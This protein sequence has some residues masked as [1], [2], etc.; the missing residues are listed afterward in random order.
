MTTPAGGASSGLGVGK[1]SRVEQTP[2]APGA[3]S[4]RGTL[5]R[6][7]L[8]SGDHRPVMAKAEHEVRNADEANTL[9]RLTGSAGRALAPELAA[10]L[11][12]VLGHDVSHVVIHTDSVAATAA[13]QLGAR[14]FTIGNEIYFA[15]GA[16]A[17][18]TRDGERL[19]IHELTH[20]AQHDRGALSAV[21]DGQSRVSSP[22]DAHEHE[23]RAMES[24]SGEAPTAP[25]TARGTAGSRAPVLRDVHGIA[26]EG[27]DCFMNAVLQLLA[28]TYSTLFEPDIN[29]V[30]PERRPLQVELQRF[31]AGIRGGEP[32]A[33]KSGDTKQL[34]A[35]LRAHKII[36]SDYAQE[37]AAETLRLLLD[38]V[39]SLEGRALTVQGKPR[40]AR[41]GDTLGNGRLG[42]TR[43]ELLTENPALAVLDVFTFERRSELSFQPQDARPRT[44]GDA[45]HDVSTYDA[46]GTSTRIEEDLSMVEIEMSAYDSFEQFM[47]QRYGVGIDDALR[48]G[49]EHHAVDHQGGGIS[50]SKLHRTFAFARL[51]Q[52]MTFVVQRFFGDIKLDDEFQMPREMVLKE[53]TQPEQYCR[54]DLRAM[55][56]HDSAEA[57]AGH[58]IAEVDDDQ[59]H[60]GWMTVDDRAV[61][62][63]ETAKGE[64]LNAP[65]R[66]A[67]GYLYSY[68]LVERSPDPP[69][70]A[71][72][73]VQNT[74]P[75]PRKR[76]PL[77]ERPSGALPPRAQ[78][79]GAT[80]GET[81]TSDKRGLPN[82]ARGGHSKSDCFINAIVQLAAG[83]YRAKFDPER[84][85]LGED[86]ARAQ[87]LV[88]ALIC[89]IDKTDPKAPVSSDVAA[90]RDELVRRDIIKTT[91]RSED[92]SE[93]LL[94][95]LE[96]VRDQSPGELATR[97]SRTL[98]LSG[99][100]AIDVDEDGSRGFQR[101]TGGKASE[102][103]VRGNGYL[104][105]DIRQYSNIHQ[106]LYRAYGSG[107]ERTA[108]AETNRPRV[109]NDGGHVSIQGST[110]HT[111][112]VTLP[113][114]LTLQLQRLPAETALAT[115]KAAAPDLRPFYMPPTL[116]LV[117]HPE[118]GEKQYVSYQLRGVVTW[119]SAHYTAR[120]AHGEQWYDFNDE[121]VHAAPGTGDVLTGGYLYTYVAG[122]RSARP[123]SG[124]VA[125]QESAPRTGSVALSD[126]LVADYDGNA[127]MHTPTQRN[128]RAVLGTIGGHY[129]VLVDASKGVAVATTASLLDQI[130]MLSASDVTAESE[131][132]R[133]IVASCRDLV[134]A[135]GASSLTE[136]VRGKLPAPARSAPRY[137][138]RGAQG[139]ASFTR[140][141]DGTQVDLSTRKLPELRAALA[142]RKL[143]DSPE[144]QA[145]LQFRARKEFYEQVHLVYDLD[146]TLITYNDGTYTPPT[147]PGEVVGELALGFET[148][149]PKPSRAPTDA[150]TEPTEPTAEP[151]A[152]RYPFEIDALVP[153]DTS[154]GD[155]QASYRRHGDDRA[156]RQHY[157]PKT[158]RER[159]ETGETLD[160]TGQRIGASAT[161]QAPST[162]AR[163]APSNQ[164]GRGVN[165]RAMSVRPGTI[166]ALQ[167]LDGY[168]VHQSVWT[169]NSEHHMH[170]VLEL[171]EDLGFAEHKFD[172]TMSAKDTKTHGRKPLS[173]FERPPGQTTL[174][175]DDQPNRGNTVLGELGGQG[176]LKPLGPD[177]SGELG[178][179][180]WG[181]AGK[182]FADAGKAS[183]LRGLL[184]DRLMVRLALGQVMPA[185]EAD[186]PLA[187]EFLDAMKQIVSPTAPIADST[188]PGALDTFLDQPEAQ[189]QLRASFERF[190]PPPAHRG[191]D[192]SLFALTPSLGASLIFPDKLPSQTDQRA[193]DYDEEAAKLRA[194]T[195]YKGANVVSRGLIETEVLDKRRYVRVYQ[196]EAN[197][198]ARKDVNTTIFKDVH[199][200]EGEIELVKGKGA[201]CFSVGTPLRS[202]KWLE[203]YQEEHFGKG[204]NPVIRSFLIPLDVYIDM[205]SRANVQEQSSHPRYDGKDVSTN[206]DIAG[207]TDQYE[208]RE[209]DLELLRTHAVSGSLVSW[210]LDNT[211]LEADVSGDVRPLR[212]LYARLGLTPFSGLF[213][214]FKVVGDAEHT[215]D[216]FTEMGGHRTSGM[217]ERAAA[218]GELHATH[219]EVTTGADPTAFLETNYDGSAKRELPARITDLSTFLRMHFFNPPEGKRFALAMRIENEI[220]KPIERQMALDKQADDWEK[221]K[222][223]A[224]KKGEPEP[225][226]PKLP[227]LR[228]PHSKLFATLVKPTQEPMISIRGELDA[229][230]VEYEDYLRAQKPPVAVPATWTDPLAFYNEVLAPVT[231]EAARY[232]TRMARITEERLAHEAE[233]R[234]RQ[235]PVPAWTD[236]EF[237][238]AVLVPGAATQ[239]AVTQAIGENVDEARADLT[240]QHP[241][242]GR[243]FETLWE[244]HTS[245]TPRLDP[246][247]TPMKAVDYGQRKRDNE[248]VRAGGRALGTLIAQPSTTAR[249]I[250]DQFLI[251]FPELQD[252]F[253]EESN[254]GQYTFYQ[255]AERVIGQYL[256][257]FRAGKHPL[258][259]AEAMVKMILFHDMDKFRGRRIHSGKTEPEDHAR[260]S[261]Y[262]GMSSGTTR[263]RFDRRLKLEGPDGD[264]ESAAEHV[265]PAMMMERYGALWQSPEETRM[266]IAIMDGDPV[267]ALAKKAAE[268][269]K[270]AS[271]PRPTETPT[272]SSEA[273]KVEAS[274]LQGLCKHAFREVVA[275][276]RRG[277][278][279]PT[280]HAGIAAFYYQLLQFYQAD[281]SSYSTAAHHSTGEDR[282]PR[283]GTMNQIYARDSEASD[284]PITKN[285]STRGSSYVGFLAFRDPVVS[286]AISL[287]THMFDD[288]AATLA[289]LAK[290]HTD[291]PVHKKKEKP[292]VVESESEDEGQQGS[293]FGGIDLFDDGFDD[294][295]ASTLVAPQGT[296]P[297][298]TAAIDTAITAV[299]EGTPTDDATTHL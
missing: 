176:A 224:K 219:D 73:V 107:G 187:R 87:R 181:D 296:Q 272:P 83:P 25:A 89:K 247:D 40:I 212:E 225:P 186:D 27:N 128:L 295:V 179:P 190:S 22:G 93:V 200:L 195:G 237:F 70:V 139:L 101:Y 120:V 264:K 9:G 205:A 167:E 82:A 256:V 214:A 216:P 45:E 65:R 76:A 138:E 290:E 129:P 196:A 114:V 188:L 39:L 238:L 298:D 270:K 243:G 111:E 163:G 8:R 94:G 26:N 31:L 252:K 158:R 12:S 260:V 28:T 109:T 53:A 14:A 3:P 75:E 171:F 59:D 230:R 263:A 155:H 199:Q 43:S 54:Y 149:K 34:R 217:K 180:G 232:K 162:G 297:L 147:A 72:A 249:Q 6:L 161:E 2:P 144:L 262:T 223:A 220:R 42:A 96:I 145:Y 208:T 104:P 61:R 103:T 123:T 240:S 283:T 160:T 32:P 244:E 183:D 132:G 137:A 118:H 178:V 113:P 68:V 74:K 88:W 269:R 124:A 194:K 20:V 106:F 275:M 156:W 254:P 241:D 299:I 294:A 64:L 102:D 184:G 228:L 174:L 105:V 47:G 198:I 193:T 159:G 192:P 142:Q 276:A 108:F 119:Q 168:G 85:K 215:Y 66:T 191:E 169:H 49:H 60:R 246:V 130:G 172:K 250:I 265:L 271:K 77:V 131:L 17:P 4:A 140:E 279:Q 151:T 261:K 231:A 91:D 239:F 222:A 150:S 95:L 86:A 56:V 90:L 201:V 202:L 134:K 81:V 141:L 69:S 284:A 71:R 18:G 13:A 173:D 30:A 209:S 15:A 7:D 115:G 78:D 100:R 211:K 84:N 21:A 55:V 258:L 227:E 291:R 122:P 48:S 44:R 287:L 51:P 266:A 182:K 189:G 33:Y 248:R 170:R 285:T 35:L 253:D 292:V 288:V 233:L 197:P 99:A 218:L 36:A 226:Q 92:A 41:P 203:K 19:L 24:R 143:A 213:T 79:L 289:E 67:Q 126:E 16:Y 185:A 165:V 175:L 157:R 286:E 62:P 37:D 63:H 10:R 1:Q 133:R 268:A 229:A 152:P 267:G 236:A 135:L 234:R 282:T 11:G 242:H 245:G 177:R 98:D 257:H 278:V 274:V 136:A 293:L 255:H 23:A 277:G 281:S 97:K 38:F 153:T 121:L 29:P 52:V 207:D 259:S 166:E 146:Q 58:Y 204:F 206:V 235:R 125:L 46:S 57:E 110:Q 80:S 251:A 280:D 154:K 210:A 164:K 50:I 117:E 127:I 273:P 112:I 5:P 221:Q 116:E 148:R